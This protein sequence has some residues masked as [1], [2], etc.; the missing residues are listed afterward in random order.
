MEYIA[1]K[2]YLRE[3]FS[4]Y[5]SGYAEW[6]KGEI[7]EAVK[8]N[9]EKMLKCRTPQ[10]GFHEYRCPHCNTVR[11][12]P[13]SCKSRFCN[14]CGKIMTDN[15][16]EE[17][18]T[19]ILKVG[20]HHL[21]FTL[22]WQLRAIILINRK[23]M[24]N[25]LFISVKKSILDWTSAHGYTP[26]LYIILHTY[27]SDIKFNVHFHVIITSGGISIDGKKWI[28]S[29]GG[30]L[31]PEEGLKK[32]WRYNVIHQMILAN[33]KGLLEMPI[34]K[35]TGKRINIRGL[36]SV[37]SKL[38]WYVYIGACLLEIGMTVKYVG[39]YTKK[40]VLAET[41]IKHY[42]SKWVIF[43]YKDYSNGS[44][45]KVKKMRLYNFMTHLTN[46]IADKY[47]RIVR[48]YGIFSNRT[49]GEMLSRAKELIGDK[50]AI[51][52]KEKKSWRERQI[53][54]TGKDPLL[55][56]KCQSAMILVYS[57]FHLEESHFS[58]LRIDSPWTIIPSVQF[59]SG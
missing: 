1:G 25:L 31:M 55:C 4:K 9:V 3:I 23:T 48:G 42:D 34:L 28:E 45:K 14:S 30:Y 41:R 33:N 7:R 38:Q 11:L 2:N 46:H 19:E 32:R 5:W 17:R 58:K 39:R 27:G 12:V 50:T 40:P 24:L 52:S 35:K 22:P 57:C 54:R 43:S 51:K 59:D 13:H 15:W 20:Y 37:I 10:L 26:G 29:Q 8:E 21:V 16:S 56:E 6:F 44:K 47:F 49:K 53:D 36:I 18:L